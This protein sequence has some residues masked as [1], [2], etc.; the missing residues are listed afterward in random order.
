M[1]RPLYIADGGATADLGHCADLSLDAWIPPRRGA[2]AAYQAG[3][4]SAS[5]QWKMRLQQEGTL[6]FYLQKGCRWFDSAF[7]T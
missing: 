4:P 7:A 6:S 2:V 5:L 1:A 3:V